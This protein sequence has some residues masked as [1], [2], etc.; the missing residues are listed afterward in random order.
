MSETQVAGLLDA[1]H[2]AAGVRWADRDGRRVPRHYGDPA[3][4]YDAAR[5]DAVVID[6]RDRCCVR[7]HGRDPLKMVQGLVTNDVIGAAAGQGVYAAML[8]AK[9]KMIADLRALKRDGELLLELDTAARA[10]AF[11]TFRKFVPPLFAKFEDMSDAVGTLSLI[12]PRARDIVAALLGD[13]PPDDAAE[14][15]F[16]ALPTPSGEAL[17]VRSYVTGDPGGY[18]IIAPVEAV[19]GLWRSALAAG[20]RPAGLATLDVLRIEA[21]RPAWGADL[22][23]TV[24]PLEADLRERA[25]SQT[26]GCYTGQE[27]IVRILHRGHVNRHLRGLLLE[28][29]PAPAKGTELYRADDAK[30]VGMVTSACISPRFGQTIALGYVRREVTPPARL[31]LGKPDGPEVTVVELPFRRA[32]EG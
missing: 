12:G 14:H 23:D 28:E 19:P 16:I 29:L 24:I 13:A 5:R 22:D 9:G 10:A 1:E 25:L 21:G 6:R 11:E 8:T 3:A 2:D 31:R 17:I 20:A 15:A 26:K 27:I 18:D 32:T 7:A 4:E 30:L